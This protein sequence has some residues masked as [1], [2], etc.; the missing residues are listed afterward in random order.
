[1]FCE[2]MR[3]ER[4]GIRRTD[5]VCVEVR[6]E[7]VGWLTWRERSGWAGKGANGAP[8]GVTM[9]VGRWFGTGGCVGEV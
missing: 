2:R 9:R 1:V 3:R 5:V 4:G 8:C 7:D 6:V